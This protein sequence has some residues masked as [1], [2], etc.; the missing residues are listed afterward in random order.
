MK[1]ASWSL[2]AGVAAPLVVTAASSGHYL[3]VEVTSARYPGPYIV[4]SVYAVFDR[5]GGE[6]LFLAVSGTP[7]HTMEVK[8]LG[9]TFFQHPLGSIKAPSQAF[10][11]LFPS[12]AYDSFVTIGVRTSGSGGSGGVNVPDQLTLTPTFPSDFGPGPFILTNDSWAVTPANA[13]SNPFD[14]TYAYGDGRLLLAQFTTTNGTG[15]QGEFLTREFSADIGV[16]NF[17]TFEHHHCTE[18]DTDGDGMVGATDLLDVIGDWG[19]IGLE[20]TGDVSNDGL[21][22]VRDFI[23]VFVFWGACPGN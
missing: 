2:V 17:V 11:N 12:L 7:G 10:V 15:I 22:N 3:G 16:L 23:D 13:Q 9:G 6:D 5:P 14:P 18:V 8:I 1:V 4:F 19:C 20:C 21:V